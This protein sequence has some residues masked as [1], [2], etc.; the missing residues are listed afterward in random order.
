MVK[1]VL[2]DEKTDEA[3]MRLALQEAQAAAARGEVP[4]GAV[5]VDR[6][7]AI[8]A[9]AGNRTIELH[10]PAG[11]AELLALRA[12][13]RLLG[14]Y[15]L[16][17]VTLYVTLEPCVM[18]A[19][20][21]IHARIERLVFG[22]RDPKTGGVVSLYPIGQDNRLNHAFLLREGVLAAECAGLLQEFFKARRKNGREV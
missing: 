14:N 17:G 2:P 22:T 6:Q 7:G 21:M 3:M 1:T 12:A 4:V 20:A 10:D 9:A 16:A 15:R 11:H 18:C 8:L 13:G 5:L 19:G